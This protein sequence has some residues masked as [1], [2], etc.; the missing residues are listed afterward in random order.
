MG[1]GGLFFANLTLAL[2]QKHETPAKN[3]EFCSIELRH[4]I[5]TPDARSQV[6]SSLNTQPVNTKIKTK[7]KSDLRASAELP[8]V[9]Y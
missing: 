4:F 5:A 2:T 9:L 7:S 1:R 3:G 8:V 6:H